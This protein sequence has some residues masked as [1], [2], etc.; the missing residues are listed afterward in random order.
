MQTR[1]RQKLTTIHIVAPFESLIL[2]PYTQYIL[3]TLG[4]ISTFAGIHGLRSSL[5][6]GVSRSSSYRWQGA[7]SLSWN[8]EFFRRGCPV[9]PQQSSRNGST[10]TFSFPP[11]TEIDEVHA[12]P[13]DPAPKLDTTFA[14]LAYEPSS[15]SWRALASSPSRCSAPLPP[16]QPPARTRLLG[17]HGVAVLFPWPLPWHIENGARFLLA[18]GLLA[19]AL[20]GA[21]GAAPAARTACFCACSALAAALATTAAGYAAAGLPHCALPALLSCPCYAGLL[22]T[23]WWREGLIAEA[24]FLTG[25]GLA[26]ARA[27]AAAA[28]P[29]GCADWAPQRPAVPLIAT[30]FSALGA[31]AALVRRRWMAA[32]ARA[33][34]GDAAALGAA[35]A[36]V[37][38]DPD[39]HAALCELESLAAAAAAACGPVAALRQDCLPLAAA[40][41]PFLFRGGRGGSL[42]RKASAGGGVTTGDAEDGC[43][44]EKDGRVEPVLSPDRFYRRVATDRLLVD[45]RLT[46]FQPRFD[47]HL[48]NV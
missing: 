12:S 2:Y 41:P 18:A 3:I 1:N 37:V 44:A 35:W 17:T 25:L 19:V 24:C 13:A 46:I 11:H 4:I 28:L 36:A 47:S 8:I 21:F 45:H 30:A 42:E 27:A 10:T 29:P 14:L 33:V 16:G 34:R 38:A 32:A 39:E 26:A 20:L 15:S 7:K 31:A 23:L 9:L 5:H 22:A 6:Y 40:S 43:C 48:N